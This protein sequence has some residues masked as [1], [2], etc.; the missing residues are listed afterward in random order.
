MYERGSANPELYDVESEPQIL[1]KQQI[2][3]KPGFTP[4]G[5]NRLMF[6]GRA[7]AQYRENH[8]MQREKRDAALLLLAL[9][10]GGAQLIGW[11]TDSSSI[12]TFGHITTSS[13]FPDVSKAA[14]GKMT[15]SLQLPSSAS[16]ATLDINESLETFHSSAR[17]WAYWNLLRQSPELEST[18]PRAVSNALE[19]ALCAGGALL[20][21]DL[22]SKAVSSF[23]I[24]WVP[25][26][27]DIEPWMKQGDCP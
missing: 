13:P 25:T 15:V 4:R 1:S 21:Q 2:S 14:S 5:E 11:V 9:A 22:H 26:A 20:P 6:A 12:R 19:H 18:A 10:V 17:K 16:R 7:M 8:T 24:E 3:K 27:C 23:S